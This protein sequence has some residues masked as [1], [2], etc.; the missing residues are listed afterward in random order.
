MAE[1]KTKK[2]NT[3]TEEKEKPKC[4]IIMPISALDGYPSEHWLEVKQILLD[5]ID[6]IG[7]VG[8][9]V[10]DAEETSIIQKTIVQNV[11]NNDIVVCDVSGKNPN[12]MFELGMRLAFDKATIII[13]DD[14]TDYSFDTSPIEHLT[15]RRDLRFSS[16]VSFK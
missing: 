8:N 10:S 6:S 9:L 1:K 5:V 12:V 2:E 16:I 15:Y 14:I 4:G 11:Y 7:F 13:K 3:E